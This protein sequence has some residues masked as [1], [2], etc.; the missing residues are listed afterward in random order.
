VQLTTLTQLMGFT[1]EVPSPA[2]TPSR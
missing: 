2:G 1:S